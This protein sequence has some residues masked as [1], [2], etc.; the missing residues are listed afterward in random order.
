MRLF[1]FMRDASQRD[2]LPRSVVVD[3]ARSFSRPV[4][5]GA[6]VRTEVVEQRFRAGDTIAGM[7]EDCAASMAVNEEAPRF[8]HSSAA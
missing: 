2:N 7:A 5:A 1:P 8:E 4:V 6:F 3:P